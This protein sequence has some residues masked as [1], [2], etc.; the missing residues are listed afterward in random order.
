[1]DDHAMQQACGAVDVEKSGIRKLSLIC[2]KKYLIRDSDE[3]RQSAGG[4]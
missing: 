1:M 4:N 2:K 3:K